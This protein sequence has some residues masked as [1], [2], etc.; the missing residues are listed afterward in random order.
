MNGQRLSLGEFQP[1]VNARLGIWQRQDFA[2]RLWNRDFTVWSPRFLP[3]LVDRLGWLDLPDAMAPMA[4]ELTAFAGE[5]RRTGVT[6]VV[7]LGMGGSSLAPEVFQRTMGHAPGWPPLHVLD[8]THPGAVRAIERAVDLPRTLFVV[9]SKSGTTGET[10]S[11]LRYFWQRLGET[12]PAPGSSFIAITDPRTPLEE[13]ARDRSFRRVFSGPPDVGGRYSALSV[14]GLVPAALI[15]IAIGDVIASARTMAAA[16]GATVPVAANPALIL[17]A[18]MGELALAGRDKLT[19][20]VTAALEAFPAWIEQLV[21]ESTGKNGLGIVPV[22][23]EPPRQAREYRDDRVF[24]VMRQHGTPA[25]ALDAFVPA[26]ERAGH[27]VIEITL[28]DRASL[29][30]EFF[31]WELATAAA[32]AVLGIHPFNQPDVQV[33]KDLARQ[34]MDRHD[35]D[36]GG[37]SPAEGEMIVSYQDLNQA[38]GAWLAGIGPHDYVAI[39]AYLEPTATMTASLQCL[40]EAVAART[41]LATTVGYGPRFL[42]STGQLHKGGPNTGRFLQ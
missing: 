9:S 13:L 32:G 23:G 17:G 10:L 37:A 4:G 21:A 2:R 7:L 18:A 31:R 22:A 25:P 38:A 16:C 27:P 3:E 1:R 33:S 12:S 11:F 36:G 6:A 28:E 42:H 39:Q 20:L 40:R 34:A 24:V 14:F 5:V 19:F 41:R 26:L 30:E 35:P 29:A 15:G 8:S